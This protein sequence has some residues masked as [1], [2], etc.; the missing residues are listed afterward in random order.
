MDN[1]AAEVAA[2]L[3]R[4]A[5]GLH[6]FVPSFEKGQEEW[7]EYIE[8]LDHYFVANDINS[9]AKRKAILLNAVGAQTY[10]LIRTL[11]SPATL[12]DVSLADIVAKAQAHFSPKPSVIVKHFE[13]NTCRQG[14]AE[15]IAKYVAELRKLAQHCDYGLVLRDMLR[16]RL[17]CGVTDKSIQRCLLQTTNFTFDK[18]LEVALAMEAA[19][20]DST[21]ISP[22]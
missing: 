22:P 8:R 20:K 15:S 10:R 1:P 11:M 21:R 5:A 13:F 12:A 3:P 16:D 4:Q 18:A 2:A 6:G 14:E 9:D 7:S 19:D 17:V